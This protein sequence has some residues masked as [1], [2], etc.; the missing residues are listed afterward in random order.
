ML[1]LTRRNDSLSGRATQLF[2]RFQRLT[3][4]RCLISAT[5]FVCMGSLYLA[6]VTAPNFG[7]LRRRMSSS[8][9][10]LQRVLKEA[11]EKTKKEKYLDELERGVYAEHCSEIDHS[12][13]VE[14]KALETDNLERRVVMFAPEALV[15]EGGST[16]VTLAGMTAVVDDKD[17]DDRKKAWDDRSFNRWEEENPDVFLKQIRKMNKYTL[18]YTVAPELLDPLKKQIKHYSHENQT[19][20]GTKKSPP[21][22]TL[23]SKHK[24]RP[25]VSQKKSPTGNVSIRRTTLYAELKKCFGEVYSKAQK[26]IAKAGKCYAAN[27]IKDLRF[28]VGVFRTF[29]KRLKEIQEVLNN[30][31]PVMKTFLEQHKAFPISVKNL[32]HTMGTVMK[33]LQDRIPHISGKLLTNLETN[34]TALK[35]S[36][37][38]VQTPDQLD[39]FWNKSKRLSKKATAFEKGL[40]TKS[41]L[42]IKI[43]SAGKIAKTL[44]DKVRAR[45]KANVTKEQKGREARKSKKL[46]QARND[47]AN[48]AMSIKHFRDKL[49]GQNNGKKMKP[50]D[51]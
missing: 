13:P 29:A 35:K 47:L 34:L 42:Y 2:S 3:P 23:S 41:E 46:K 33:Q 11:Q 16:T 19:A 30:K 15:I 27:D 51:H 38:Q 26:S 6:H 5:L 8:E 40:D 20:S 22:K 36:A 49:F 9:E 1:Y 48:Q 45:V 37:K 44:R 32:L 43:N 12:S 18:Q 24:R 17:S 39:K 14:L 50:I 25:S 21:S 10:R 31:D 28:F 4:L 7:T